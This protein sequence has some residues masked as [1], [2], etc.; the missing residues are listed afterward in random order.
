MAETKDFFISYT[1]ADRD[2]AE[3]VAWEL[4]EAGYTCIIQAWHFAPSQSFMQR[5]RQALVETRHLVAIL[6]NEYLASEFAGAELDAALAADPRGLRAKLIPIRV[7]PCTPDEL[8]RSRI[9][10]D[11]VGKKPAQARSDLLLGIAAARATATPADSVKFDSPPHFPGAE[12][13]AANESGQPVSTTRSD[14]KLLFIGMDIGRGL[15]LRGQYRQIRAVLEGSRKA[16]PFRMKAVFDA[17]AET[18][19]DLLTENLPSIVHFSGN[20]SGG[21]ILL[22]SVAGGVTTIPAAALAGLLQSLDRAVRLAI[23]D[24]CDSLP[25]AREIVGSV[26]LAMGVKGKP[27]DDDATAFYCRFYKAL[28]AGLSVGAAFG[29]ARAEHRFKGM[30]TSET[31]QLCARKG[32]DLSTVSFRRLSAFRN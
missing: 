28:A 6:S 10:I 7:K 2:W 18:L 25:C 5:M 16:G 3:W 22:R 12:P 4:Q 13:T 32:L 14:V 19:P 17:T 1:K 23:I 29:Q 15:N 8:I 9:Y 27:Y 21:R 31:P 30:P 24:T 20:Q 11:L 26:D